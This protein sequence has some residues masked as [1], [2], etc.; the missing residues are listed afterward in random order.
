MGSHEW[1]SNLLS[2]SE[3]DL[4]WI[5]AFVSELLNCLKPPEI[6]IV[7]IYIHN[8]ELIGALSYQC[9]IEPIELSITFTSVLLN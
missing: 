5:L 9:T 8:L 1:I 7:S 2:C 4:V 6:I 3:L